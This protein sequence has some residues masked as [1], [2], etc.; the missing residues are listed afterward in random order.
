VPFPVDAIPEGYVLACAS[1]CSSAIQSDTSNLLMCWCPGNLLAAQAVGASPVFVVARDLKRD[2]VV[3]KLES[4]VKISSRKSIG[5]NLNYVSIVDSF[6]ILQL[7]DEFD[8][9]SNSVQ[10]SCV[11]LAQNSVF[12]C[13]EVISLSS[14]DHICLPY[15]ICRQAEGLILNQNQRWEHNYS[16]FDSMGPV[17]LLNRCHGKSRIRFKTLDT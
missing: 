6:S 2:M 12:N 1:L 16:A 7:V 14:Q 4:S 10:Y 17:D 3:T 11:V 15:P 9:E 8:V 5:S 13:S